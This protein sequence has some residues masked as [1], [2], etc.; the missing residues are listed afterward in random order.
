[1]NAAQFIEKHCNFSQA[2]A[3]AW[4]CRKDIDEGSLFLANNDPVI[5]R[6]SGGGGVRACMNVTFVF[7]LKTE[8]SNRSPRSRAKS[9]PRN[10][11]Y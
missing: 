3:V 10:F 11:G 5:W 1:V 4:I 2:P 9:Q 6:I 7:R 8:I